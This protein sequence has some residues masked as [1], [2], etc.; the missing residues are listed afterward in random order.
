MLYNYRNHKQIK[1]HI[2]IKLTLYH[3]LI[4]ADLNY[5]ILVSG[6]ICVRLIKL[7]KKVLIYIGL[8]AYTA[9]CD[10]LFKFFLNTKNF[11]FIANAGSKMLLLTKHVLTI[12]CRRIIYS[13]CQ[14]YLIAIF[15]IVI[16]VGVLRHNKY[17]K[18]ALHSINVSIGTIVVWTIQDNLKADTR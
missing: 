17:L 1:R 8:T 11:R 10:P 6:F 13:R 7:Q 2:H 14:L 18:A 4:Q 3:A 5:C 12:H 15:T 9:H 16:L